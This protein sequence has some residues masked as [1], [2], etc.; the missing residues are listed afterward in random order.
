MVLRE[1]TFAEI[2]TFEYPMWRRSYVA[3]TIKA[4][5]DE[6]ESDQECSK[7]E[8]RLKEI[9]SIQRPKLY[10]DYTDLHGGVDSISRTTTLDEV[11]KLIEGKTG[12]FIHEEKTEFQIHKFTIKEQFPLEIK[13]IGSPFD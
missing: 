6:S 2:T 9:I 1:H 4:M 8:G 5:V 3:G 13:P 7:G 12:I 10:D 11:K